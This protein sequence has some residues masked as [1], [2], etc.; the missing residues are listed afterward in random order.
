MRYARIVTVLFILPLLILLSACG[1]S[2]EK[3]RKELSQ[4]NIEYTQ[5]NFIKHTEQGDTT[6][7]ELFLDAGMDINSVDDRGL[8]ALHVAAVKGHLATVQKLIAKGAN[9]NVRSKRVYGY[10]FAKNSKSLFFLV[11]TRVFTVRM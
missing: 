8:T 9:V 11:N 1:K 7:I 3:A 6:V 10:A 4:M 2:P 5:E